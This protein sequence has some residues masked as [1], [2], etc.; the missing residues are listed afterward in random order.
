MS[1]ALSVS[2]SKSQQSKFNAEVL[3]YAER[4]WLSLA[5]RKNLDMD[6]NDMKRVGNNDERKF[7][8]SNA[9]K[10]ENGGKIELPPVG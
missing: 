8:L 2:K 10:L 3:D 6:N 7:P 4:I 1:T 5:P 9:L